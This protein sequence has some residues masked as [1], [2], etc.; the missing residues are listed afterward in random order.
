MD[1]KK[2]IWREHFN[3]LNNLNCSDTAIERFEK[4]RG[5][6]KAGAL[7]TIAAENYDRAAQFIN[8]AILLEASIATLNKLE[9]IDRAVR[10]AS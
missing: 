8:T 10:E 1:D 7:A 4:M 6:A 3:A 9:A 5:I 2:N